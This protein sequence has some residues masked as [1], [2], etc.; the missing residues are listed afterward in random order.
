VCAAQ[1]EGGR[2]ARGRIGGTV[3]SF[4]DDCL[5]PP[6]AQLQQAVQSATPRGPLNSL[7]PALLLLSVW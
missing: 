7:F 1:Q 4:V 2:R 6:A 5:P 3:Q